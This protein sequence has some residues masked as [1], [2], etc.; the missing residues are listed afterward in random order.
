MCQYSGRCWWNLRSISKKK[1]RKKIRKIPATPYK[2]T[3]KSQ[4]VHLGARIRN[5]FEKSSPEP[6]GNVW[7]PEIR[8]KRGR[9]DFSDLFFD[10]FSSKSTLNSTN[11]D[12]E[13]GKQL[14]EHRDQI[15]QKL[16]PSAPRI[17]RKLL[18]NQAVFKEF[19]VN[20]P[21]DITVIKAQV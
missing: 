7:K 19:S 16:A 20:F 14:I 9:R 5:L 4:F 15:S 1:R 12:R 13:T 3:W 2:P 6:A 11:I 21:V 17:N 8:S 10:G 18:I